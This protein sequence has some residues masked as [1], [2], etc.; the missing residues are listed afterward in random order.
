MLNVEIVY[1]TANKEII[2]Y[3][4]QL[5]HGATVKDAITA[6]AIYTTHPETQ[7]LTLGIHAKPATENTP[8]QEGDRIEI[9]RPLSL[10]P[11]EKRRRLAKR[12]RGY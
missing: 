6:S 4:L 10:D 11:K 3:Q 12:P 2:Q 1:I 9:Y 5:E 8:L 7:T